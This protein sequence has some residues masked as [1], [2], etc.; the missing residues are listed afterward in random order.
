MSE[1]QESTRIQRRDVGSITILTFPATEG[2]FDGAILKQALFAVFA[3]Q[4]WNIILDLGEVCEVSS[5][6]LG[7]LISATYTIR[8][9]HS[10]LKLVG[11]QPKVSMLFSL[12]RLARI[13][14]IFD[15]LETAVRS[16][17]PQLVEA[18]LNASNSTEGETS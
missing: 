13:Y 7:V 16:F 6:F 5:A 2:A 12:T 18:D 1:I 17:G 4:R 9:H 3:E 8:S 14:E 15:L 10:R 11:L